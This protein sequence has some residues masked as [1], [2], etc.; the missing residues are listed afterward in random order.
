MNV[1][2]SILLAEAMRGECTCQA[3]PCANRAFI[4]YSFANS[5]IR[6]IFPSPDKQSAWPGTPQQRLNIV[7]TPDSG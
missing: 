6:L 4:L 5:L 7:A 1:G 2:L 3:E